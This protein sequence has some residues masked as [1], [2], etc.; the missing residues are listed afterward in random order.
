MP[1]KQKRR[2]TLL[3][4]LLASA[5]LFAQ[6][7]S[8]SK[9]PILLLETNGQSISFDKVLANLKIIDNP[10]GE[11][12]HPTDPP[13]YEGQV[14]IRL[15][16]NYSAGLPQKPYAIETHDMA[17]GLDTAVALLGM[18]KEEDWIL[19]AMWNDKSFVRNTLLFDLARSLGQWAP[20]TRHVELLLNGQYN[21]I[22]VFCEKIKRDGDRVD[23]EKLA[24]EQNALPELPGGYIFRHDYGWDFGT[25]IW[26]PTNCPDRSLNFEMVY[27]KIEDISPAQLNYISGYMAQVETSLFAAD[28][29]DPL[30]GYQQYLD[31]DSWVDYFLLGELSG[32]VDAYKKSMYYHKDRDGLLKLGPVWDFDWAMK[33]LSENSFPNGAGWLYSVDPCSQDVLYVPYFKRLLQDSSFR[34]RVCQ[35][36]QHLRTTTLD[37]LHIFQYIDSSALALNEAQA[38]HFQRWQCLGFD[39]GAPE[40]PPYPTTY[41]GEVDKLKRFLRQRIAWM[42]AKLPTIACLPAI[43]EPPPVPVFS[44]E[45]N[46][47]I[48]A[49]HFVVKLAAAPAAGLNALLFN[50]AGQRCA[51]FPLANGD[52]LL[53]LTDF[54]VGAYFLQVKMDGERVLRRVVMGR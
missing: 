19:L 34:D 33:F 46:P 22:Y 4:A 15:R 21:G 37:T 24:P 10:N 44:L 40:L 48:G 28:F 18:P 47:N 13:S 20:H 6:T 36:W 51:Q 1:I 53:D 5:Q 35:R 45:I 30:T 23:I 50:A 38:R 14:S 2:F 16:G 9:L 52:N 54:P 25:D 42:D 8:S 32:N 12:N 17:T 29:G 27:P 49:G 26:Q 7:L 41:A 39:S 31:L 3:L 11:L 43:V